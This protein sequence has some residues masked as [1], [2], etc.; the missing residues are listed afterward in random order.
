MLFGCV[1]RHDK[2]TCVEVPKLRMAFSKASE[3]PGFLMRRMASVKTFAPMQA[4]RCVLFIAAVIP[5]PC[6]AFA[7]SRAT[8]LGEIALGTT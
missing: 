3:F 6:R 5:A 8:G 7:H 4:S 1:V 2:S